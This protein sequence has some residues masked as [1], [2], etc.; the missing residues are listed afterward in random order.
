MFSVSN[1]VLVALAQVGI[2]VIGILFAGASQKIWTD[3]GI[4]ITSVTLF[5]L[6]FG[7]LFLA[8]PLGWI[9]VAMV[10]RQRRS[11]SDDVKYLAFWS[12]T[13]LIVSLTV[14]ELYAIFSPWL[15]VFTAGFGLPAGELE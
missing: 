1:A 10:V 13:A 15:R 3:K 4:P 14:F 12:G 2:V 8:I 6:D 11:A 9:S 5:F 7:F